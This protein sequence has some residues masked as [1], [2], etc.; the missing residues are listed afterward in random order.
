MRNFCSREEEELRARKRLGP[1]RLSG[2]LS[3]NCDNHRHLTNLFLKFKNLQ[4]T[5]LLALPRARVKFGIKRT[6]DVANSK[7]GSYKFTF[8]I[9]TTVP[10]VSLH[11]GYF[12]AQSFN[13]SAFN[14]SF[15]SIFKGFPHSDNNKS[16][17]EMIASTKQSNFEI[18][19]SKLLLKFSYFKKLFS[20]FRS[21]IGF[22]SFSRLLFQK[23]FLEREETQRSDDKLFNQS[24]SFAVKFPVY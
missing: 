23:N 24:K 3:F 14:Q 18:K 1:C 11:C 19:V 13:E 9:G 2:H 4:N 12:S 21:T 6:A 22:S 8:Q 17:Q 7:K 16:P 20:H 15:K 10:V 5:Y